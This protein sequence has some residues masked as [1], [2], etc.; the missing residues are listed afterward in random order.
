MPDAIL[1]LDADPHRLIAFMK[2][3]HH[4]LL[5]QSIQ[6]LSAGSFDSAHVPVIYSLR[7]ARPTAITSILQTMYPRARITADPNGSRLVVLAN[8]EQQASIGQF[9][10]QLEPHARLVTYPIN[11]EDPA[12]V[13]TVLNQLYPDIKILVDPKS[14][15][16]MASTPLERHQVIEQTIGQLDAS[17]DAGKN[18]SLHTYALR[19]ATTNQA[20]DLISQVVKDI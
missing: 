6:K 19:R 13:Q 7:L 11:H 8:A 2:P 17:A 18:R 12:S 3:A 9:L 20:R 10:E 1:S 5:R 14:R 16:I 4:E 15:S